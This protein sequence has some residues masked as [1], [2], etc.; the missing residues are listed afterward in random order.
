MIIYCIHSRPENLAER[1]G[2]NQVT[3][4]EEV[5]VLQNDFLKQIFLSYSS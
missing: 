3:E 4:T 5:S 1:P 2:D